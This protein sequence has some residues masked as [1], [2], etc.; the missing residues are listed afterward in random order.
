MKKITQLTLSG[1]AFISTIV[2]VFVQ[3][4]LEKTTV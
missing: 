3:Q 1:I 4:G 2:P